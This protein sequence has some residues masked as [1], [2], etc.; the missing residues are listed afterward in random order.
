MTTSNLTWQFEVRF[1]EKNESTTAD[2][3]IRAELCKNRIKILRSAGHAA[4]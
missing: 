1:I 3:I 4:V 2:F